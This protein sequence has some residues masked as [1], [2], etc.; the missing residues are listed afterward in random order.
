MPKEVTIE[1]L[2]LG[3][4]EPGSAYGTRRRWVFAISTSAIILVIA[5]MV[6]TIVVRSP[7]QIAAETGAPPRDI[8]TAPV[9]YRVLTSTVIIRGEVTPAQVVSL[10]PQPAVSGGVSK[11]MITRIFVSKGDELGAGKL[12]MEISGRPVFG[13][14]GRLPMYRDLRPGAVGADVQQLQAALR[15]MGH[16]TGGDSVG[17]FGPGTKT[18]LASFYASI[19]YDP[20]PAQDDGGAA[21][22]AAQKEVVSAKRALEDAITPSP[23]TRVGE[24]NENDTSKVTTN[25]GKEAERAKDDLTAA[26]R[27]LAKI[28]A[29]S[30]P[31]L[32]AG[33]VV[34]LE[35]FPI[36]VDAVSGKVGSEVSGSVMTLSAGKLIVQ[37]YA[38]E[39]QKDLLRPGQKVQV[40][41]ELTGITETARVI[42]VS[43]TLT[44]RDQLAEDPQNADANQE[45]GGS[46]YL[47]E[48]DSEKVMDSRLSGQDVRVSIVAA[49]T[50]EKALVVPITAISSSAGGRT[51]VTVVRDNDAKRQ[52][53][54]QPVATGDGYVA[55]IP[56]VK[57]SLSS[58][59]QVVTGISQEFTGSSER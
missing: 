11:A 22:E 12:L 2:V 46:G 6:A 39:F 28:E 47:V 53:E 56:T 45:T 16:S 18:A 37:A 1:A 35:S 26:R 27:D 17:R 33:E 25:K 48:I 30:G 19:G 38:P 58:R 41:S 54:I 29:A 15:K 32:P 43:D 20:L 21:I 44:S 55:V 23:R 4:K 7:A 40:L 5:G 36:R 51:V 52:I 31:M 13:L 57:G 3:R 49:S 14:P 24:L 34:F 8:L 42:S 50:G 10:S 9:E 59:D